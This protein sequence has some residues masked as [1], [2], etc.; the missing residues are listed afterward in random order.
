[1]VY[2]NIECYKLASGVVDDADAEHLGYYTLET[3]YDV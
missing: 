2:T 3:I 1:M